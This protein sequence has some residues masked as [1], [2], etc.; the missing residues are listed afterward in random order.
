VKK[1]NTLVEDIVNLFDQDK[2][3]KLNEEAY[4]IFSINLAKAFQKYLG[5]REKRPFALYMSNV[6]RPCKRELWYRKNEGDK[7]LPL[8]LETI[9]KFFLGDLYEELLFLFARQAG[10]TV[11]GEQD[12]MDLNGVRGRRDGVID[13]HLVDVKSASSR[14][15]DK[16]V[17]IQQ[18]YDNDPFGYVDQLNLYLH[19]AEDDKEVIDKDTA[20]FFAVDKQHGKLALGTIPKNAVD[21]PKRIDELREILDQPKAPD[22]PFAPVPDGKSGNMKL[23]VNCS[24]CDFRLHCWPNVRTFL[25]SSGPRYLTSVKRLPNVS[26]VTK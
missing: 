3:F 24:Y 2:D 17:D 11:T 7:A 12:S 21:Y 13:G 14:S 23:G 8:R 10:H 26:E 1:I 15:F 4:G 25:Y 20:S 18:L 16:F 6:G 22:R 19:C 5:K 9:M